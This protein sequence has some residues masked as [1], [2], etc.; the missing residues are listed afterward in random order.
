MLSVNPNG[1]PED[2]QIQEDSMPFCVNL[3]F[4]WIWGYI[5]H[6]LIFCSYSP[7]FVTPADRADQQ[8]AR[9]VLAS[10]HEPW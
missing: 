8:E 1:T 5:T 6:F 7:V 3:Q 9:D 4:L 10:K 2:G